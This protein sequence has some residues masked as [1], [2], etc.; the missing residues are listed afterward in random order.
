V[1]GHG[2]SSRNGG[3]VRHLPGYTGASASSAQRQNQWPT[4]SEETGMDVEYYKKEI[5]V[6]ENAEHLKILQALWI[7][8]P[9]RG[10]MCA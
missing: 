9:L 1:I 8:V 5:C 2:G 6:W 10:W 3:G 7:R 4:L